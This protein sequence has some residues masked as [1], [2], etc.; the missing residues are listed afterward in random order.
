MG[1]GEMSGAGA[2]LR[3]LRPGSARFWA[4]AAS[5]PHKH[6]VIPPSTNKICPLTKLDASE[7]KKIAA[8]TSSPTSPQRPIGVRFDSQAE[9]FSSSTRA[10][11]SSVLK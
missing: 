11:L 5:A 1:A 9:N 3:D 6:A 10:L 8:P 4:L 2:I 7:A